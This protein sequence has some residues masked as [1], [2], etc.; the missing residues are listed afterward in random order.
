MAISCYAT[1]FCLMSLSLYQAT[2]FCASNKLAIAEK[3]PSI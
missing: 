2:C 1:L 3:S